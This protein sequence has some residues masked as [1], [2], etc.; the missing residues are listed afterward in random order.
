[1]EDAKDNCNDDEAAIALANELRE[2]C[3]TGFQSF[4]LRCL[5]EVQSHLP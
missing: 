4:V 5:V 1:M 2:Q 3:F